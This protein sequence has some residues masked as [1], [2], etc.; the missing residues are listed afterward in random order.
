MNKYKICRWDPISMGNNLAPVPMIYIKPDQALLEFAKKNN[1]ALL[2]KISGTNTIY[3]GKE[4]VGVFT[5][6]SQ[7]PNCRPNFF[8]QTGTYVI[9][10]EAGWYTYPSPASLGDA[11]IFGLKQSYPSNVEVEE[12]DTNLYSPST[13]NDKLSLDISQIIGVLFA[14][15]IIFVVLYCVNKM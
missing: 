15:F 7:V 11:E 13:E 10:L 4:M 14:I 8:E 6:S 5:R 3:D 9:V 1:N 2:I 12:K